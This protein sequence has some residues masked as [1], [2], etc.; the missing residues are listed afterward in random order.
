MRALPHEAPESNPSQNKKM[1]GRFVREKT[2][3]GSATDK[4]TEKRQC[5]TGRNRRNQCDRKQHEEKYTGG[6]LWRVSGQSSHEDER[7]KRNN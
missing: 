6:E 1:E 2:N 3:T 4:K 5:T 7:Q